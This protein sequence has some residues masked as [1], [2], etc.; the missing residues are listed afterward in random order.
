MHNSAVGYALGKLM[1]VMGI[2]LLIPSAFALWDYRD[3]AWGDRL[4]HAE[5]SGFVI[6]ISL[7]LAAGT[8]LVLIFRSG[9][10]LQGLKE[11]YAIVALGWVV[12]ALLAAIP[13]TT[14]LGSISDGGL[15]SGWAHFTDAYFEVMS[16]FTTTGATIFSDVEALPRSILFLRSLTHWLGGMGIITLALV[17]FPSMGVA[18]YQI[19]KGEV[20]GVTKDKLSPKLSQTV[21]ILWGVYALL[22]GAEVILLL[23][24]GMNLFEAVNHAF[25]TLATGGFSTRNGSIAAYGD[26]IQWVIVIFMYLAGINFVLH[27]KWL[28][29]DFN[30]LFKNREFVFY[31]GIIIGAIVIISA[32]LYVNGP[33][34]IEQA[35]QHYR[36]DAPTQEEF[37]EHYADQAAQTET[38]YGSIKV[39]SFQTLAIVTTTGFV[40][41]DFDL[42]P[43]FLRILM[44]L[45]MFFGGCAGSTGGGMK[46]VRIMIIFKVAV[47][48]LKRMTQPKLV[49]PLRVG[50]QV[51]AEDKVLRVIS[52]CLLFVG[53]FVA[54]ALL[55]TLFVPDVTTAV[56]LSVATI[57]NIG[58][59]L[60]GIGAVENYGWLPLTAKWILILSMLLGRLEIFTVLI[61]FR[62]SVW[63]K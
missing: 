44:V 41:T 14:Y 8:A 2:L 60:S 11:G 23:V 56:T 21:A 50:D 59:G 42:W 3:L 46:M 34:D 24:G 51:V 62:P 1:Q 28:R 58:P 39:A 15:V 47:N 33:N 19:F 53:L 17:V 32:M 48:Q 52:F 6:A 54:I 57:A 43:D 10:K 63:Q 26:Y 45:L 38:L 25:A 20:P 40:I 4:F 36:H 9:Q 16:G 29:G 31:N 13:I 35:G 7:A 55:M 61:L 27:L 22:T 30:S 18:A 12:M 49:L 37:A 5:M